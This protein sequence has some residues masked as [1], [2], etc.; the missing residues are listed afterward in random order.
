M[1]IDTWPVSLNSAFDIL[2]SAFDILINP[3]KVL[4]VEFDH[5]TSTLE[6]HHKT[7]FA[8]LFP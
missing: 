4:H 8:S 7:W 5:L 1:F 2:L 3:R 6:A